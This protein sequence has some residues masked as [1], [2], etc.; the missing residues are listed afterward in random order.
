MSEFVGIVGPGDILAKQ[1][2]SACAGSIDHD[3]VSAASV[4]GACASAWCLR[5]RTRLVVA[6]AWASACL[7]DL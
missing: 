6:E 2:V 4:S 3:E 7:L 1:L 5:Q